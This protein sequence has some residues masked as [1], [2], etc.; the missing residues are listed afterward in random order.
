MFPFPSPNKTMMFSKPFTFSKPLKSCL[1]PKEPIRN[2]WKS[3]RQRAR[4]IRDL[5]NLSDK[6]FERK[7]RLPRPVFYELLGKITPVLKKLGA[8][9]GGKRGVPPE[10]RLALTLRWLAGGSYLEGITEYDFDPSLFYKESGILWPCVYAINE[11]LGLYFP[12]SERELEELADTYRQWDPTGQF[13]GTVLAMD[14]LVVR[15]RKPHENETDTIKS[16]SNRKDCWAVVCLAGCDG[17]L[18]FHYWA[19]L[20]GSANDSFS[21][22]VSP[23]KPML[24]RKEL[25]ARFHIIGDEA[26]TN[27]EQ[28]C[29]PWSGRAGVL[30]DDKDAY[31][32]YLSY[33][34]QCIERAFARLVGRWGILWRPLQ[35]S[36]EKWEAVTLVVAKL[37]NLCIDHG[38][39]DIPP[40]SDGQINDFKAGSDSDAVI[41]NEN[42]KEELEKK[43]RHAGKAAAGGSR[44]FRI[45]QALDSLG[46]YRPVFSKYSKTAD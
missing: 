2:K 20:P 12:D 26:F 40:F 11:V 21:W 17:N 46:Y 44:R 33:Q 38:C 30:S 3:E 31:N 25:N 9:G 35:C 8:G 28:L 42:D 4:G 18:K 34:R 37:H 14:G 22:D 13:H 1:R 36:L 7:Y 32:Y 29:T 10:L 41:L 23:L 24:D 39:G 45:T 43:N 16:Y 5:R 19:T 15:T 6:L 27:G